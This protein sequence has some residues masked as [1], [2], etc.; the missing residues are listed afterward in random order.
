[1]TLEMLADS[2]IKFV[3]KFITEDRGQFSKQLIWQ[4]NSEVALLGKKCGK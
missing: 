1:M 4:R 2:R 3:R